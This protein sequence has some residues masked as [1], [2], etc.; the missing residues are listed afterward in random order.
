M[1]ERH[2]HNGIDSPEL[3]AKDALSNSPQ[4]AVT[5]ITA[6]AGGTYT[7]TEQ[8]MI[9]N[10]KTSLNDLIVKLQTIGLLK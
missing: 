5:Q 10:I 6:T 7:A 1:V 2:T 9:N 3:E 8:A 4:D